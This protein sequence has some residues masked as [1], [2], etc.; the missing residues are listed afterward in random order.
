MNPGTNKGALIPRPHPGR[1]EV[2]RRA[3]TPTRFPDRVL[4]RDQ[5]W[6]L[7]W[8]SSTGLFSPRRHGIEPAA[9]CSACWGGF[10]CVYRVADHS[11]VPLFSAMYNDLQHPIPFSGG[12][13]LGRD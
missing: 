6:I 9:T 4:Y 7:A 8:T 2:R 5:S 10:V 12:L 1:A 13:L 11:T 3:L